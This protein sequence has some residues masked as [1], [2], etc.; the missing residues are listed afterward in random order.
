MVSAKQK[1]F[2]INSSSRFFGSFCEIGAA[3]EVV[4]HFFKAGKASGSVAK[5]LSAY[6]MNLSDA[7]YGKSSKYVSLNRLEAMLK[8]ERTELQSIFTQNQREKSFIKNLLKL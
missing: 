1:A 5:S 2:I 7:Y 6:D 4:G 3:Q 8:K